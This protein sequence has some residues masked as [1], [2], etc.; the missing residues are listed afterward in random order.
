META[1]IDN[2]NFASLNPDDYVD[3]NDMF[4]RIIVARGAAYLDERE[5][6]WREKVDYEILS[7]M[8]CDRCILGQ[9]FDGDEYCRLYDEMG[10][11][12]I[13]EH[14]FSVDKTYWREHL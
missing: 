10:N 11:A 1:M 13:T 2:V 12:W 3:D 8:N 7:M 9:V 14:G 5:P 4:R 6:N